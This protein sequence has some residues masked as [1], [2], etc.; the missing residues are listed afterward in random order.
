MP[1][2]PAEHPQEP[3]QNPEA[4][5]KENLFYD[6]ILRVLRIVLGCMLIWTVV[7]LVMLIYCRSHRPDFTIGRI[8]SASVSSGE[9]RGFG[10]YLAEFM[11]REDAGRR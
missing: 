7:S 9:S 10:S 3:R 6:G 1:N 11:L 4:Q 2:N 5:D 8:T